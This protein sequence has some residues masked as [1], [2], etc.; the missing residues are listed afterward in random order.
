[1]K[2]EEILFKNYNLNNSFLFF[3]IHIVVY[4]QEFFLMI[5]N[6]TN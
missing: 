2:L 3:K 6:L 5:Y 1:M 4:H